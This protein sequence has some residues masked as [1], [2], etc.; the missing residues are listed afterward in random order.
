VLNEIGLL[1]AFEG[2]DGSG[3]GTQLRLLRNWLKKVGI[4]V[5]TFAQPSESIA[6]RILRERAQ[7]DQ[8]PIPEIELSLFIRDRREQARKMIAPYLGKGYTVL[9]DRH[10][11]SSVAYQGARGLDPET[12]LRR[13]IRVAPIPDLT[14]LIDIDPEVAISRIKQT[15][16]TDAFER[17]EYLYLVRALYIEWAQKLE[18]VVLIDGNGSVKEVHSEIRSHVKNLL[19]ME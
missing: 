16:D 5:V 2:I 9:L 7:R 6:G 4:P 3:K 15:R 8:R 10:F 18:N 19:H 1:I 12:I 14:I 11:L 17:C 13:N